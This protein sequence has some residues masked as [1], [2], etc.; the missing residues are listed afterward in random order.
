MAVA[1]QASEYKEVNPKDSRHQFWIF[2]NLQIPGK[3]EVKV[4]IS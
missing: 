1:L 4:Q 3:S 2:L